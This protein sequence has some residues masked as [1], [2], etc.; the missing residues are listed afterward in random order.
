M[1]AELDLLAA[2][3]SGDVNQ[4]EAIVSEDFHMIVAQQPGNPVAGPDW[5]DAVRA[6]PAAANYRIEQMIAREAGNTVLASFRL[7]PPAAK[8]GQ[9]ARPEVFVVDLWQT[10]G[11]RWQLLVRHAGLTGGAVTAIPGYVAPEA[12][13]PKKY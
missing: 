7:K 2:I 8:P 9:A 4:L 5:V 11:P 12:A 10:D 3:K 13:P 6:Q 1:Q